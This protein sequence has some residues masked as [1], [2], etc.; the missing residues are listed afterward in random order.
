MIIQGVTLRG[1]RVV[2][3]S[4][5]LENLKIWIDANNSAS[6]NGSGTSITD[7]SGNGYTQTLSNASA[8]TMLNGVKCFDCSGTYIIQ[9]AVAGATLPTTG[10]TYIA[11]A[12][13]IS[14]SA[15]WRTLFRTGPQDHP[16][17]IQLGSNT[18]GMFDNTTNLFY[19]AGYDVS[20]FANV[21]T[22]WAVTG[23]S[24]GQTFYI[25]GNQVG[26]V[27]GQTSAGNE[28]QWLGGVTV[29]NGQP[30][31]YIANMELYTTK[32]TQEQILQNYYNQLSRFQLPNITTSSLVLWYD[33][34]LTTSYPGSGTAITNLANTSLSG[35]MSNITYID[36]YFSYNGT[37]SQI[38]VA[39]NALLEPGSGNWTM[40][41]WFRIS[42]NQTSVI[43]G[44]FDNGGGSQ[45][46]SYSIR[47]SAGGSL[48]AQ[49][50]DGL[51]G[52]VNSTSY[53]TSLATW[54]QVVYVWKNGAVKTLETYINGVTIGSVNHSL[55]SLL[56]CSN[57]L[58]IGSYNG[59]EYSQWFNGSI[60]TV[61]LYSAAL[62][63]AEVLQNYNA[64]KATYGL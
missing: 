5:I 15:S 3:A 9:T 62:T 53:Q 39:D 57:P 61:R 37:T 6:Y 32:L 18:L 27:I 59:G 44:K 40:E 22:Q 58:Y 36:P 11:W 38:S 54:Y 14:S 35:T 12:R 31:G 20:S 50:G 23:D 51:G 10:F 26:T 49:F 63:G 8:Y 52:Y 45:D 16:L 19:S 2:D 29:P 33:P 43:A 30:F 46:V 13:M 7:L 48:F 42:A 25:N 21:W 1:T 34:D 47:V 17:L 28:H 60:G 64:N 4:I 41:A 24:S 56:N 55:A